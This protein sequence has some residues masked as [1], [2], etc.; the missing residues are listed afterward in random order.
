MH[1][2][3]SVLYRYFPGSFKMAGWGIYLGKYSDLRNNQDTLLSEFLFIVC[4]NTYKVHVY[5]SVI[6][7]NS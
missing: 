1:I 4:N 3:K 6:L 5:V 7:G 2:V